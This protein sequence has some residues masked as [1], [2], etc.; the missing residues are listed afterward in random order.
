MN[1]AIYGHFDI[2]ERYSYNNNYLV[3]VDIIMD[4]ACHSGHFFLEHNNLVLF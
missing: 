3:T 4:Y 1:I 2:T